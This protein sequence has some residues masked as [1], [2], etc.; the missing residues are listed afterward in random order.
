M[1]L[2]EIKC[3]NCGELFK[4]KSKLNIYC[5]ILCNMEYRNKMC[6]NKRRKNVQPS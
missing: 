6:R 1:D 4:P 3:K 5:N 2:P